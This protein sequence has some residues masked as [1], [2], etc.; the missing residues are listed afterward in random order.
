MSSDPQSAIAEHMTTALSTLP[1]MF[2]EMRDAPPIVRPSR[3]WEYLNE[4]NLQQLSAEGFEEFKRTVNRNYFQF[5]LSAAQSQYLAVARAWVRPRPRFAVLGATLGDP[6]VPAPELP[7]RLRQAMGQK[8]YAVYLALL[9]EYVR[10]RDRFGLLGRLDEPLLGRPV[11]IDY[12]GHRVSEDLCNS[13]LEFTAVIEAL[14]AQPAVASA[15][16]LGAGYGRLAW[17]FLAAMP[18]LRYTV[19]DI[20][21]ALAIAERYLSTLFANR[22]VF[23]F[24]RFTSYADIADEFEAA[25]IAFLT[26]NQLELL[27]PQGANLFLNVSSLH[28]MRPDQIE[29]YFGVITTHCSGYFYTKQWERSVNEPDAVVIS[30]DDYPVP[31]AWEVVFDRRHP[32]QVQFFEAFYRLRVAA[33]DV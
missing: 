13:V 4:L 22:R 18:E 15:I 31:A 6:P 27:P 17:V 12:R 29:H 28:E 19:V 14:P 24:R 2:D 5:Q 8:A 1:A 7:R 23:G 11:Y 10:G 3:F 33:R 26:P 16:E 25:Q 21:P 32:V 9:W 30:H 20:P